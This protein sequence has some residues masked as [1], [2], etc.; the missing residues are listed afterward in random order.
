[1]LS[2]QVTSLQEL[3]DIFKFAFLGPNNKL[4]IAA[5]ILK[6]DDSNYKLEYVPK[7]VG[8]YKIE[9]FDHDKLIWHNPTFV[10]ICDPSRVVV[11]P[12]SN[13]LQA[14]ECDI[15]GSF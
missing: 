15:N 7:E 1:M 5:S 8:L 13:C 2:S 10:E 3:L 6:L 4:K 9:I 14:K 12:I 11:S